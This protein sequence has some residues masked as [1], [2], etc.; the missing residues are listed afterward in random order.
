MR[1][2]WDQPERRKCSRLRRWDRSKKWIVATDLLYSPLRISI[3]PAPRPRSG[4]VG[5]CEMVGEWLHQ[6]TEHSV[7]C[8]MRR[9]STDR[10]KKSPVTF[11]GQGE[12]LRSGPKEKPRRIVSAPEFSSFR[13]ARLL[14][15]GQEPP[16][17]QFCRRTGLRRQSSSTCDPIRPCASSPRP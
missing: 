7:H 6:P 11:R 5:T 4:M 12:L 15:K 17:L 1:G 14:T 16:R 13:E 9:G 8:S 3:R 2:K 10:P